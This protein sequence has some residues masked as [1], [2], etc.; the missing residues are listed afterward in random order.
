[1]GSR[2]TA[3][4]VD[5]F[6]SGCKCLQLSLRL[7]SHIPVLF[8]FVFAEYCLTS[9]LL[10]PLLRISITKEHANLQQHK[11]KANLLLV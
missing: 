8:C 6:L 11:I 4:I 9:H 3:K 1:M 10:A 2:H 7:P 5:P